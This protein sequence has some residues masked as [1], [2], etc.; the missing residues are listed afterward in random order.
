MTRKDYEKIAKVFNQTKPRKGTDYSD[1]TAQVAW[2]R[3]VHG[4][5]EMLAEDN[6]SFNREKFLKACGA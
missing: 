6:P 1:T 5:T 4:I 2:L 3:V